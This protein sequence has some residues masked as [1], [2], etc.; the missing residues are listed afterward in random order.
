MGAAPQ[1]SRLFASCF[2][3]FQPVLQVGADDTSQPCTTNPTPSPEPVRPIVSQAFSSVYVP[4]AP[5]PER[6]MLHDA[7]DRFQKYQ[8][9]RYKAHEIGEH[10][11]EDFGNRIKSIKCHIADIPLAECDFHRNGLEFSFNGNVLRR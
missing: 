8:E 9:S 5:M 11:W 10:M 1:S 3:C 2:R 6:I 7:L 4:P